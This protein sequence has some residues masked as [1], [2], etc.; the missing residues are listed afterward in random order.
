[1]KNY[2]NNILEEEREKKK[3]GMVKLLVGACF[4]G[5]VAG[6]AFEGAQYTIDYLKPQTPNVR[7]CL[8]D[9]DWEKI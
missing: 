2:E 9:W 4:F 7:Y 3:G 8:R 1:M 6:T 5:M